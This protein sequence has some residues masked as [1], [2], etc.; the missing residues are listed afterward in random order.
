MVDGIF[1]AAGP[2]VHAGEELT[3]GTIADVAPTVLYAL[4]QPVPQHMDGRVLTEIFGPAH[5]AAHP[6]RYA[7]VVLQRQS[8]AGHTPHQEA[9]MR[10]KLRGLGY[11]A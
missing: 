8:V 6:I 11:I 2:G 10:D 9:E 3:G 1:I 7:D 5:L 4:G